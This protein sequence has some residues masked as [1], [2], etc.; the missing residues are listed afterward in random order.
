MEIN[1]NVFKIYKEDLSQVSMN[2]LAG[3]FEN[4]WTNALQ[5]TKNDNEIVQ[6]MCYFQDL[7]EYGSLQDFNQ[8]YPMIIKNCLAKPTQNSDIIHNTVYGFGLIG[9]RVD[10]NVYPSL[11]DTLYNVNH[12]HI[13][14]KYL[15]KHKYQ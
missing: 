14:I 10:A 12:N 6:A 15:Y 7:M 13:H 2:Y 8:V 5:N 9:Q 1:G 11:H 3:L 4:I